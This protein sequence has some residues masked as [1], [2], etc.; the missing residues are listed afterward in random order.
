[1]TKQTNIIKMVLVML[2]LNSGLTACGAAGGLGGSSSS[3]GRAISA[4]TTLT[5]SSLEGSETTNLSYALSSTNCGDEAEQC[6]TP[7]NI[8]GKIY[9]SGIMVGDTEG[10]SVGPIVGDIEDPSLVTSFPLEDFY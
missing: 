4:T 9:Y 7:S 10:Y 5:S 1:M 8:S 6:I 3:S 2:I